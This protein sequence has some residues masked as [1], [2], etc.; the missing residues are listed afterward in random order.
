MTKTN[1]KYFVS[2]LTLIMLF[3]SCKKS[4]DI[5]L[6]SAAEVTVWNEAPHNAFTDLIHFNN[7]YYCVFREGS[8][9]DSYD[10]KIRIVRSMDGETW[11]SFSLIS[12]KDKD[13]RDPHF[14]IDNNDSLSIATNARNNNNSYENIVYKLQN[15]NFSQ[16]NVD[17]DY[18]LWSFSKFRDTLYSMGYNTKQTCFNTFV[19]SAKSKIMLFNNTDPECT[20]FGKVAVENLTTSSFECP[21]EAAMTFTTDSNL[22]TIVRDEKIQKASHI[23]RSKFP[24]SYLQW[25]EFPYFVR[26]PKLALLPDGKLFLA[27]ASM[28]D[29]DRTYYAIINPKDFS[30]EKIRVFPS[31]GDTGYPGV[32]IEGNTALISY[33]SSHEGNAR[34]YIERIIY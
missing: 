6:V 4:I 2:A 1:I 18:W 29:Y 33:Y 5:D 28:F 21:C 30:V 24:F 12:L 25:Q 13:L 31:G 26:G 34:V 10:G 22:I 20:S 23:G 32:I 19:N 16:V 15:I 11:E 3:L 27:A 7:I 17:N 8:S 9:H 14:F